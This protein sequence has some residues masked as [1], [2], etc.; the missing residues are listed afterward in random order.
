MPHFPEPACPAGLSAGRWRGFREAGD[1]ALTRA[2]PCPHP[3]LGML[4]PPHN[5]GFCR[6]RKAFCPQLAVVM[7]DPRGKGQFL[8]PLT[9]PLTQAEGRTPRPAPGAFGC[10]FRVSHK[11]TQAHIGTDGRGGEGQQCGPEALLWGVPEP[12][13]PPHNS[14]WGR[15]GVT[16]RAGPTQLLDSACSL[17]S[18]TGPGVTFHFPGAQDCP[19]GP[20]AD[21]TQSPVPAAAGVAGSSLG[22]GREPHRLHLSIHSSSVCWAQLHPGLS[23]GDTQAPGQHCQARRGG[24]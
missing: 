19:S 12:G 7:F 14:K 2:P 17:E 24:P 10:C 20:R 15:A 6:R 23:A 8:K 5:P 1:A 4:P 16:K 3:P 13:T 21:P 11:C 22:R 9:P 18:K